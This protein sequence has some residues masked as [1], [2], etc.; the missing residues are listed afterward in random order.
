MRNI[1]AASTHLFD[2]GG[3]PTH[4]HTHTP[5]R[6]GSGPAS[7]QSRQ[8]FCLQNISCE[9]TRLSPEHQHNLGSPPTLLFPETQPALT[10]LTQ[11]PIIFCNEKIDGG[12]FGVS[13]ERRPPPENFTIFNYLEIVTQTTTGENGLETGLRW[14]SGAA[15]WLRGG[16]VTGGRRH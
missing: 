13:C 10:R 9:E 6:P 11:C 8:P 7:L 16:K 3:V 2:R 15:N 5:Y 14:L 1:R 4:T 12:R